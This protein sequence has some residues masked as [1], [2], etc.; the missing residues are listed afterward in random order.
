MKT[1]SA[2]SSL[3]FIEFVYVS[4]LVFSIFLADSLVWLMC[5]SNE[6]IG[7]FLDDSRGICRSKFRII[8]NEIDGLTS[9]S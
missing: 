3:F 7:H 5:G 6:E 9:F 1:K 4:F 8:C 2:F